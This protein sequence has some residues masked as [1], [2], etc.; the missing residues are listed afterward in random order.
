MLAVAAAKSLQS[1]PTLRPHRWQPTRLLCP[2]DSPGQ[3]TSAGCCSLDAYI[4]QNLSNSTL[5]ICAVG[6]GPS[7]LMKAAEM[8]CGFE[9]ALSFDYIK[10]K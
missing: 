4:S 5:S 6:C 1:C 10:W 8:K 7:P 9:L 2:W 3:N